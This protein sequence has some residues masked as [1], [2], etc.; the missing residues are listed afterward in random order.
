MTVRTTPL[1]MDARRTDF[2]YFLRSL[3]AEVEGL[4]GIDVWI[5]VNHEGGAE[6]RA[7][8]METVP[9]EL[10]RWV[11]IVAPGWKSRTDLDSFSDQ[12]DSPSFIR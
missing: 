2:T 5:V 11:N 3:I 10:L 9:S 7:R 6:A 1:K 12:S 8:W 4:L